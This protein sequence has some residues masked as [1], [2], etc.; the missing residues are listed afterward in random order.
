[1]YRRIERKLCP[2]Y[3]SHKPKAFQDNQSE[4]THQNFSVMRTFPNMSYIFSPNVNLFRMQ[5]D[6]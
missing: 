3:I 6:Y 5:I 4:R 2:V 1:M